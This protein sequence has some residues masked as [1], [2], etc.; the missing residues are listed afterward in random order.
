MVLRR[1]MSPEP[2]ATIIGYEPSSVQAAPLIYSL[3]DGFE[4][5]YD[6]NGEV[7]SI[8]YRTVHRLCLPWAGVA[9]ETEAKLDVYANTI[10]AAF[11]DDPHLGGA[12]QG[13]CHCVSGDADWEEIG[14]TEYRIL[15]FISEA[16]DM[17][18][19]GGGD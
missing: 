4:R 3:L 18:P 16:T 5:Q 6:E 8:T 13:Q 15:D 9:E 10:P 1:V 12:I 19:Y 7:V 17:V 14:K 11:E 2:L